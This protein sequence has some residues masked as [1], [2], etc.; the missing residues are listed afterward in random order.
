MEICKKF[1]AGIGSRETPYLVEPLIEE[2]TRF[3]GISGYTLRSGGAP[4]ADFMFE[5]YCV[6]DKQIYLP[7]KKFN[8]NKSNLYIEN[9]DPIKVA[10]A[11]EIAKEN[12]PSWKYLSNGAKNL[13]TR[14]TF[15]VLGE[16]L[17]TPVSFIVCWTKGGKIQG[18]TGQ[19]L[20]IAKRNFIPIF[21]LYNKECL[22]QIRIH[23]SK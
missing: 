5:S 12:H 4:G 17:K 3:L 6:H 14:N 21:N 11:K 8:N 2:I 22:H 7:W 20:R 15:Q 19:A 10:K 1:Y 16:D 18:G 13:M 9:M 23:I